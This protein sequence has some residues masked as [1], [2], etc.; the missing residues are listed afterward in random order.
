MH[1]TII[2]LTLALCAALAPTAAAKSYPDVIPLPDGFQPEGIATGRGPSFYVGS[3]PTGDI[4]R[5][6]LRTGRGAVF[7]HAPEGR[8]ATG[9]K[10]DNRNR[11]FV[12]GAATGQA[13]VY[14][15]KTG[16]QIASYQLVT[17]TE[18]KPAF[19]ND[20][21]VTRN[22]AYFTD[23]FNQQLYVLEFGKGGALPGTAKTLPITGDLV[24]D[25][26]PATFE[27]NGIAATR[28][29]KRL[30]LVQSRNGMLFSADPKTGATK[31]IPLAGGESV[32]R[33][34]GILLRGQTLYVVQ[35]TLEQVASIRLARDLSG[36][37]V[38]GRVTSPAFEVPTT[39]AGFG[40]RLYVVNAQF[41]SADPKFE[42]VK[43]PR[44]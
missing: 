9:L 25:T 2:A 12:A 18:A 15:A 34:D 43:V 10:V 41:G 26:D 31:A 20:V 16:G 3:I 17:P 1:K 23:S 6:S 30:I 35:N 42:V 19:I 29:G 14:D 32:P 39:I 33:G 22:A 36:G 27:A 37:R 40:R 13:Y 4:Y 7:I 44:R 5:G 8:S 11:L 21:I 24:Y 28:N 38:L